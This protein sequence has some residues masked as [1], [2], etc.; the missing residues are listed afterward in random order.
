MARYTS[1]P[2]PYPFSIPKLTI[3]N[4]H[5]ASGISIEARVGGVFLGI[6]CTCRPNVFFFSILSFYPLTYPFR[7]DIV[8]HMG[9]MEHSNTEGHI[10]TIVEVTLTNGKTRQFKST[11]AAVNF[12]LDHVQG[13][14]RAPYHKSWESAFE[15]VYVSGKRNATVSIIE[16]ER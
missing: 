5:I 7:K 14:N 6:P 16:L 11:G 13:R 10:M 1:Y 4:L 8:M 2:F 15:C 9:W 3:R 12:A